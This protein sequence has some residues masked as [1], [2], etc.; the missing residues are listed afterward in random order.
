MKELR[1]GKFEEGQQWE[2]N[3]SSKDKVEWGRRPPFIGAPESNR[4]A[5]GPHRAVLPLQAAVLPLG[6]YYPF[7]TQQ[8]GG[9]KAKRTFGAVVPLVLT[10]LPLD[11]TVPPQM[12]AVLLLAS[13]TKKIHSC[14]LPWSFG[15]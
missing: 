10:V 2:K 9:K 15:Q 11:L 4:Y 5:H 8:R 3:T 1:D 6:R 7:E 13:D 12:V 14:L